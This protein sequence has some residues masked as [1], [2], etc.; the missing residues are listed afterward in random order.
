[1]DLAMLT[2]LG[3]VA[4]L[5]V[6]ALVVLVAVT[7]TS[8]RRFAAE[9][10][11]SRAELAALREGLDALNTP[12]VPESASPPAP[13]QQEYV[14]TD[15]PDGRTVVRRPDGEVVEAAPPDITATTFVSLAVGESLVKTLSFAHG[16]R[17]ALS[18][19]NRNRIAFEMR[20]EVRR[21][22]KQRKRD[23][24]EAR[25]YLRS[26]ESAARGGLSGETAA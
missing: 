25:R 11:A 18:P 16:L 24:K 17:R 10:A 4:A 20:R 26:E 15:L 7:V 8:R 12:P 5:C 13:S 9:L 1:M 21:S 2:V 19:E 14:I 6:V 3:A 22:R 23:V